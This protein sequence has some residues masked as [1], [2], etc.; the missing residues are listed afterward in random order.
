VEA[1]TAVETT[2]SHVLTAAKVLTIR[3]CHEDL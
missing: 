2:T 1:A 3:R